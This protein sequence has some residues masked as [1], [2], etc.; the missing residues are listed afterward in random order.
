V[1]GVIEAGEGT[2][3]AAAMM[4]VGVKSLQP[5]AL[6]APHGCGGVSSRLRLRLRTKF[7]RRWVAIARLGGP[8]RL[9][10]EILVRKVVTDMLY[11]K[12]G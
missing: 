5:P 9:E 1:I 8:S 3:S 10:E 7:S 12:R 2:S 4:I 6:V 11:E